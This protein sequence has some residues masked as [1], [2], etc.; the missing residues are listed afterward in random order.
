MIHLKFYPDF[1]C[2]S[3]W[4]LYDDGSVENI[5]PIDIP[6]SNE[7][8]KDIL[9]WEEEYDSIYNGDYPPNSNFKSKLDENMFFTKGIDLYNRLKIELPSEYEISIGWQ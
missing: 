7:L 8:R 4:L 3:L 5:A 1:F 2:Y 9:L 6:I